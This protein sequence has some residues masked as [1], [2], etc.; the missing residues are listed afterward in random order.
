MT[1][2]RSSNPTEH[3]PALDALLGRL[4]TPPIRQGFEDRV[5]QS[6]A[7]ENRA[8][9]WKGAASLATIACALAVCAASLFTGSTPD[10]GLPPASAD[11]ARLV[12]ALRSPE[13]GTEDLPLVA[14]LGE[15]LEAELSSSQ[16]LWPSDN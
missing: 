3:D 13:L 10:A 2:S 7:P 9:P 16:Q 15:I 11:E 12:A 1:T 14:K 6:V 4:N 8:R 5:I